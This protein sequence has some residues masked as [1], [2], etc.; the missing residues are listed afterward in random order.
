MP[1]AVSGGAFGIGAVLR[2]ETGLRASVHIDRFS[3]SSR[4][5]GGVNQ[6]HEFDGLIRSVKRRFPS[7]NAVDKVGGGPDAT[8]CRIGWGDE[9]P[10]DADS[11]FLNV[12]FGRVDGGFVDSIHAEKTLTINDG[13]IK[14]LKRLDKYAK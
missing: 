5:V 9:S 6:F 10:V 1:H 11:V 7:F 3:G 12:E 4:S 2:D 8:H 13:Y 14:I